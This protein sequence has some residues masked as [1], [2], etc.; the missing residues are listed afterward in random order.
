MKE[1]NKFQI[2]RLNYFEGDSVSDCCYLVSSRQAS[3]LVYTFFVWM[4][5]KWTGWLIKI[6]SLII[7]LFQYACFPSIYSIL[8]WEILDVESPHLLK[9]IAGKRC[10]N[11]NKASSERSSQIFRIF[12]S[13]Y[14]VFVDSSKT[15]FFLEC[16][17]D[18][19]LP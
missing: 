8:Q 3:W 18:G 1:E 13:W 12:V 7:S 2:S 5:F 19:N 4:V 9:N 17:A 14:Q 16:V 10:F 6:I 15:T 11:F